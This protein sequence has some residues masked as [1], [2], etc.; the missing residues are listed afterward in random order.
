METGQ[1]VFDPVGI[2]APFWT[3]YPTWNAA[4]FQQWWE[5]EKKLL[6]KQK[7]NAIAYSMM[8]MQKGDILL[9]ENRKGI[10]TVG[11][12][13]GAPEASLLPGG[14]FSSGRAVQ[15]LRFFDPPCLFPRPPAPSP[16]SRFNGSALALVHALFKEE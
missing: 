1:W 16:V 10:I 9:A 15:W 13:Q 4:A 11:I 3:H 8:K 14:R 5:I 6:P 7:A 2:T 12:V